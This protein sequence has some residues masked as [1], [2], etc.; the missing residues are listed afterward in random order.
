MNQNSNEFDPTN[1]PGQKQASVTPTNTPPAPAARVAPVAPSTT[2]PVVQ[3]TPVDIQNYKIPGV[4]DKPIAGVSLSPEALKVKE[5]LAKEPRI[6]F[7][8][9]LDQGER[10][11][12][13]RSVT[14]NGYRCEVKKNVMV[15]LPTSLVNVLM[16]SMQVEA[17]AL[18]DNERN[19]N[20]VDSAT[21]R[22]LG[23]E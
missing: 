6:P 18:N 19:L 16:Q 11:G 5:K 4:S 13:Y 17:E 8:I 10:A 12:S 9:P 22:A 15:Q 20:N 23:L 2:G 7:F 1:I 3:E 14:I 21:R